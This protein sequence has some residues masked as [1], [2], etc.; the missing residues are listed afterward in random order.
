MFSAL[1]EAISAGN[2]D[3]PGGPPRPI[4]SGSQKSVQALHPRGL[5]QPS[6]GACECGVGILWQGEPAAREPGGIQ[7]L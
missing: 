5:L 6:G 2:L 4:D 7:G 1:F 3:V